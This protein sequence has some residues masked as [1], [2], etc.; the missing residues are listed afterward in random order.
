MERSTSLTAKS[1]P[2]EAHE[3][4]VDTDVLLGL[5][6][7]ALASNDPPGLRVVVMSATLST[8]HFVDFFGGPKEVG[9]VSGGRAR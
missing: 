9:R 4:S 3:R 2:A 7:C 8:R 6:K 5:V 1:L